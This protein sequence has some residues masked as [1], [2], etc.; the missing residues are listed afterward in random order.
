MQFYAL[1]HSELDILP[2]Q[3]SSQ[4][5]PLASTGGTTVLGADFT[6]PRHDRM[7]SLD[8]SVLLEVRMWP[9]PCNI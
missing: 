2:T 1:D 6:R 5:V 7:P 4:P 9:Q 3:Q 8:A